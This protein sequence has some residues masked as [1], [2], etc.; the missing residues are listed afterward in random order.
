MKAKP[1]E[2]LFA[3]TSDYLPYA[4]VTAISA[5][6]NANGRPVNIHFMYAD[7]V[8]PISDTERQSCF[9]RAVITLAGVG[10]KTLLR[11]GIGLNCW[12]DRTRDIRMAVGEILAVREAGLDGFCFF[13]LGARAE[14]VLPVLHTG[15]TK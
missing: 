9:E 2:L 1:I 15:P 4:V 7:I 14:A 5:I 8:K 6:D 3:A 13:D 10:A 12:P 11:P